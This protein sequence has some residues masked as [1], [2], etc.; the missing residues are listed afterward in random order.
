MANNIENLKPMNTLTEEEQRQIAV[1]G[2]KASGEAR[3]QKKLIRDNME[4]LLSLPIKSDKVKEALLKQG[5]EDTD[6]TNQMAMVV[7][8]YEKAMSGDVNAFNSIRD[9]IGQK[10]V[11]RI[12]TTEIPKII[13]DV[14]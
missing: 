10:P 5:I 12:E 4:L 11:E 3:R 13:D 2:G 6:L 1:M 9:T 8:M 7:A 14:E